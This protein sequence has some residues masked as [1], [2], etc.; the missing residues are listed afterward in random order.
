MRANIHVT[1]FSPQNYFSLNQ[2]D[3]LP[4]ITSNQIKSAHVLS[5]N[6]L[7]VLV[8]AKKWYILSCPMDLQAPCSSGPSLCKMITRGQQKSL[9]QCGKYA[10]ADKALSFG[11][12]RPRLCLTIFRQIL[13][14]PSGK[15]F[16]GPLA[17]PVI[18]SFP[19]VKELN[20]RPHMI[21]AKI[22]AYLRLFPTTTGAGELASN[23]GRRKVLRVQLDSA[24]RIPSN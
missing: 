7:P 12:R 2:E 21:V 16:C 11:L 3:V 10:T 24:L 18:C 1:S 6:F 9:C 23:L 22:H 15:L 20:A 13:L 4:A 5:G 14:N 17:R 8:T 19:S